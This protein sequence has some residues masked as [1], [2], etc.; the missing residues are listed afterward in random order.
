MKP[1]VDKND[2]QSVLGVAYVCSPCPAQ[3]PF[4]GVLFCHA[5]PNERSPSVVKGTVMNARTTVDGVMIFSLND[6]DSNTVRTTLRRW[7]SWEGVQRSVN[8]YVALM[9]AGG[10]LRGV[11]RKYDWMESGEWW[12]V[13]ECDRV[14]YV[15]HEGCGG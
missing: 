11:E 13:M 5:F 3:K 4:G 12:G 1:A 6:M 9:E 2:V 15:D 7:H 8:D 14:R 10:C